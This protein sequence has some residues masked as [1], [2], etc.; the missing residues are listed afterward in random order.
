MLGSC[1][2]PRGCIQGEDVHRG[3]PCDLW[4]NAFDVTC[5][6]S[7]HQLRLISTAAAYIVLVVW[8]VIDQRYA[9]IQPHLVGRMNNTLVKTLPSRNYCCRR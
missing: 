7:L 1:V 3:L 5:M 4:H 6:L 8:P 2:C 9:G